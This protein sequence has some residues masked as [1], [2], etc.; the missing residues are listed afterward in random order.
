MIRISPSV[1]CCL[2]RQSIIRLPNDMGY[3]MISVISVGIGGK[4]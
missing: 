1:P 4:L 3:E 2:H